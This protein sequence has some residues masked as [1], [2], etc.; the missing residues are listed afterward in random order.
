MKLMLQIKEIEKK[1][2]VAGVN[3]ASTTYVVPT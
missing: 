1:V 3:E 2:V